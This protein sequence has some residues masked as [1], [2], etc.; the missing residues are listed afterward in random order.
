MPIHGQPEAVVEHADEVGD[1]DRQRVVDAGDD[2]DLAEQ[3]EPAGE[4]RP[5]RTRSC[6]PAWPTSST[7]PPAVGYA[8]Q[9][10][11]IAMPTSSAKKPTMIQPSVM[12]RGPPVA[13]PSQ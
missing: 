2:A 11:P 12:T 8:E 5:P 1:E 7:S 9:I 10:S 13:M 4:P 3:V 6:V